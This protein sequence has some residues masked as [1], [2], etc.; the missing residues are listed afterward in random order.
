MSIPMMESGSTKIEERTTDILRLLY[1]WAKT[2]NHGRSVHKQNVSNGKR[3]TNPNK[4]QNPKNEKKMIISEQEHRR[5]GEELQRSAR[6]VEI[7]A[8]IIVASV[9]AIII[10]FAI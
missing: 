1:I 4:N 6:R 7:I 9:L 2:K 5:I 10:Y 3:N 8:P